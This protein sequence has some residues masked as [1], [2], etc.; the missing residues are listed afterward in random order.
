MSLITTASQW[1]TSNDNTTSQKKR[2]PMMKT[3][4]KTLPYENS[5]DPSN[6]N[7]YNHENDISKKESNFM[8]NYQNLQPSTV[9]Q[10]QTINE[11]R[12]MKIK[13]LLNKM[14]VDNEGDKLANFNP[15]PAPILIDRKP[16]T[17]GKSA[18]NE[19]IP[20]ELL[21][22]NNLQPSNTPDFK[23]QTDNRQYIA[24]HSYSNP[25]YNLGNYKNAYEQ[26]NI[27]PKPYYAKMG[28]GSGTSGAGLADDKL[29]EKI[30]YMI[31]LLEEQQNEK[32]NNITE[33][34]VLYTFLGIFMIYVVD[35][36]SRAG[37]YVR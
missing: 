32:T 37:K 29:M 22:K 7:K 16:E 30:N 33:E 1:N 31:H 10:S 19:L 27:S 15:P 12:N 28:I 35:S 8:E 36:F 24:P 23:S 18:T 34:F 21:P 9:E 11:N 5:F 20:S 25:N 17:K 3:A 6:D 4:I 14:N 2:I 13:D 26:S